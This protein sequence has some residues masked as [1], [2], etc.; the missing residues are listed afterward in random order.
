MKSF[1]K[2]R[3][4]KPGESQTLKMVIPVRDLASYDEQNGQW[5]A[6]AGEYTFSVAANIA[7]VRG[8]AKAN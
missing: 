3:S 5:R 4:L 6:P 8:T 2:T 7:D 1:A